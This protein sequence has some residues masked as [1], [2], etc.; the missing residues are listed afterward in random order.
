MDTLSVAIIVVLYNGSA[1]LWLNYAGNEKLIIVDNTPERD[2]QL[3]SKNISY[4]PLKENKG[5]AAAQNV[6]IKRAVELGCSH[7]VFFDQDSLPATD[8]VSAL[9]TAYQKT[10]EELSGRLF[11]LGATIVNGRSGEEYRSKIH[12]DAEPTSS[13]FVKRRDVISSGSCVRT[14]KIAQVGPLEEGLFIDTVDFEWC[15][16]AASKGYVNGISRNVTLTHF[17]GVEDFTCLGQQVIISAPF[18]YFYQGRNYVRL[19]PRVYV[20]LQWKINTLLKRTLHLA[21]MPFHTKK[22]KAIYVNYFKGTLA[23]LGLPLKA[24]LK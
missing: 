23:G 7:V 20:P 15:W 2:L 11:L 12:Q 13:G 21:M 24:N 4:I 6:G 8:F 10:D 18:R 22:W 5:I 19:L 3:A 17:V 9:T 1:D 14:D 16:R